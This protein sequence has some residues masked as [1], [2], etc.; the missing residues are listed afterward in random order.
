MTLQASAK[1]VAASSLGE[2]V[3]DASNDWT[4]RPVADDTQLLQYPERLELRCDLLAQ[5]IRGHKH[6]EPLG[7]LAAT[8][9]ASIVSVLPVPVGMTTVAGVGALGCPVTEHRM[10]GA[11][12]GRPQPRILRPLTEAKR[13]P[14]TLQDLARQRPEQRLRDIPRR[15]SKRIRAL[16]QAELQPDPQAIFGKRPV[17]RSRRPDA[18]IVADLKS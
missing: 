7:N 18:I 12:L 17:H 14:V 3:Q 2:A 16:P 5:R 6:Q 1:A 10:H 13:V 8:S 4:Q 11:E 15:S 9:R